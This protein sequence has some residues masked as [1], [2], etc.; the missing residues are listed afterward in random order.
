MKINNI[1]KM[2]TLT[3]GLLPVF[4]QIAMAESISQSID[5]QATFYGGSCEIKAPPEL[6]YN[7]DGPIPDN[8]I[9]GDARFRQSYIELIGCQG[10]FLKPKIQVTGN[11]ITTSDGTKLYADASSTTKGYGVRLS[12]EGNTNFNSNNNTAENNIISTKNWPAN[13]GNAESLNGLLVF[14]GYLSCGACTAG[15]NLQNGQLKATVT[16]NFLYN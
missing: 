16:F 2:L 9:P 12:I 1:Y 15:P 5:F 6:P 3:T 11:T 14:K 8:T 13:G 10:Y 7:N 4:F